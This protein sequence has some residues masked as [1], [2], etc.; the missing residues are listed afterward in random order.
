MNDIT[1][2]LLLKWERF[3][4]HS[5]ID[6]TKD[7][8]DLVLDIMAFCTMGVRFNSFYDPNPRPFARAMEEFLE[9]SVK[10]SMVAAV[11][12]DDTNE[13]GIAKEAYTMNAERVLE[14]FKKVILSRGDGVEGNDFLSAMI[15]DK[16]LD[17]DNISKQLASLFVSATGPTSGLL[18][19]VVY[20]LIKNPEVCK[21]VH[22]E[23]HGVLGGGACTVDL[24]AKLPYITAV[25]KETLR[26]HPPVPAHAL[27]T[28]EQM[29]IG[30]GKFVLSA[31]SKILIH[32]QLIQ[33]DSAVWGQDADKFNPERMLNVQTGKN[34]MSADKTFKPFGN[35]ERACLGH[36]FAMQIAKL[37]VVSLFQHFNFELVDPV[38]ELKHKQRVALQPDGFKVFARLRKEP[39]RTSSVAMF[40]S[41]TPGA[42]SVQPSVQPEEAQPI[43]ILWGGNNGTCETYALTLSRWAPAKG[44]KPIMADLDQYYGSKFPKDGPVIIITATFNGDPSDNA[45]EFHNWLLQKASETECKGVNYAVFGCGRSGWTGT[46]QK[47]PIEID[48]KLSELGA[49]QLKERGVFDAQ[50]AATADNFDEWSEK[51]WQKLANTYRNAV[52]NPAL[53]REVYELKKVGHADARHRILKQT[54]TISGVVIE[55]RVI[56]K[57]ADGGLPARHLELQMK[58]DEMRHYEPGDIVSVL[59]TN[60]F[61]VVHRVFR[62]FKIALEQDFYAEKL[63]D[64]VGDLLPLNVPVKLFELLVNYVEL[65]KTVQKSHL[66]VLMEH[67]TDKVTLLK[68]RHQINTNL[69]QSIDAHMSI[70]DYL[71]KYPDINLPFSKF[72]L[73]L[74]QMR[75]REYSISS[76][77]RWKPDRVTLS[78]QEHTKGVSSGYLSRLQPGDVLRFTVRASTQRYFGLPER[79]DPKHPVSEEELAKLAST[80]VIMF[81]TG[82]GLA[83]FRSMIQDR[84]MQAKQDVKVGKMLL[85]FGCRTPDT[86]Y[87]YGD[88]DLK[89]WSEQGIVDLR[90]A[91]SRASE[92]SFKCAY[93][94]DRVKND[95]GDLVAA[96]LQQARFLTCGSERAA[97]GL[98]EVAVKV[99]QSIDSS[100]DK[101]TAIKLIEG[102]GKYYTDVFG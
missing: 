48:L 2:Q 21:K 6:V 87:L 28:S 76:S 41:P 49:H 42:P 74:P 91:F 51:L 72:F 7:F 17:L 82:T 60:S 53:Y 58:P 97:K 30:N 4:P 29:V 81:A 1:G 11:Q 47:V 90:P 10:S 15:Q 16:E 34:G 5:E 59:P 94:Q 44:F 31:G 57:P 35:G 55:N 45:R 69:T 99:L 25:L 92:Q 61:E 75:T 33:K 85:F 98:M 43:Y 50:K 54:D 77:A 62:H 102:S 9:G 80:P 24:L 83:P 18:S 84:A 71:E 67:T 64:T 56:S 68:L 65:G 78:Y 19:F 22:D 40:P 20:E 46:Y 95:A 37:V 66:K 14:Y 12:G 89:E 63:I 38:Y 96:Y 13:D 73:M 8:S 79:P 88:S 3:G 93:V 26:L 23:I 39:H 27:Q 100:L 52:P 36:E 32:D 86:D 70:L 101:A